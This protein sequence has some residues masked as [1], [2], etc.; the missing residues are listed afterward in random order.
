MKIWKAELI[1]F[2]N[3][4]DEWEIKFNFKLEEK[5]YKIDEK[6]KRMIYLKE[7]SYVKIPMEMEV[8]DLGTNIKIIQGFDYELDK[9]ELQELEEEM[10]ELI[11][12]YLYMKKEEYLKEYERKISII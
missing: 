9:L 12:K 2:F 10:K 6:L 4:N 5:D 1:L 3:L 8:E 7:W 11:K